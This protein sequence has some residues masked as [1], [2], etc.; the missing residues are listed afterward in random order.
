MILK[1][2]GGRKFNEEF[3]VDADKSIS[4]RCAI[5]SLLSDGKNEIKNI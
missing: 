5:F 1:V 2:K 4:H 3:V